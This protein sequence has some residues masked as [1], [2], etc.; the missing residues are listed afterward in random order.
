M[1][2]VEYARHHGVRPAQRQFGIPRKN[3]QRWIQKKA[4]NYV[5]YSSD[6]VNFC[7]FLALS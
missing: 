2:V 6:I 4:I 5:L 1:K 3:I 7:R